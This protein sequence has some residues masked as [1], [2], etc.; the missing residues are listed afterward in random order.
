MSAFR[1]FPKFGKIY[2]QNAL[3]T[4]VVKVKFRD[5][6]PLNIYFVFCTNFSTDSVQFVCRNVLIRRR[7]VK[8]KLC[9][10]HPR[11]R[12]YKHSQINFIMDYTISFSMCIVQ[13]ACIVSLVLSRP[14]PFCPSD[15]TRSLGITVACM[16]PVPFCACTASLALKQPVPVCA[17]TASLA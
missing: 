15:I 10:R 12:F 13:C 11:Q 5:T 1:I 3:T 14:V 17:C 6:V 9:F 7:S 16:Q 2:G 4:P 8:N